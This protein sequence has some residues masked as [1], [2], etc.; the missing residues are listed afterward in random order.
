MS[1]GL[2]MSGVGTSVPVCLLGDLPVGAGRAFTVEGRQVALFRTR[3]GVVRAVDA[4]CPHAG[5]PIADGQADDRVVIC[6]LH[7]HTFDLASGI[8]LTGQPPLTVYPTEV[9]DHGIVRLLLP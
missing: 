3:A 6:P 4:A 8:C 1:G 7:A 5:G 9:D 2:G